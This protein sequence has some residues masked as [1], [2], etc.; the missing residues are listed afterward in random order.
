MKKTFTGI[1]IQ[2]PISQ[3]ILSGEKTIETRTYPI[4]EK[5]IG[6]ELLIIETPGKKGNFKSRIAGIVIF[7]KSFPYESKAA[8]YKDQAFH[9]VDQDSI[10]AWNNSKPKHGWPIIKMVRFKKTMPLKKRSGIVY[11]TNIQI[12]VP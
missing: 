8:F 4:S 7:G 6:K 1:N 12:D 9:K 2:W 5:Y 11:S 10:W 3:L